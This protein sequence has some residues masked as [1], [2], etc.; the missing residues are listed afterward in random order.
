MPLC[1]LCH[2]EEKSFTLSVFMLV[3]NNCENLSQSSSMIWYIQM[4]KHERGE[5]T[6]TWRHVLQQDN[7]WAKQLK[8][9]KTGKMCKLK[10]ETKPIIVTA[11]ESRCKPGAHSNFNTDPKAVKKFRYWQQ[12]RSKRLLTLIASTAQRAL[13]FARDYWIMVNATECLL[14]VSRK[15]FWTFPAEKLF[16]DFHKSIYVK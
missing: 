4:Y 14:L 7:K 6:W 11:A 10:A 9:G 8:R 13:N 12:N 1:Y 15:T 16:Y 5:A 3:Q 2:F